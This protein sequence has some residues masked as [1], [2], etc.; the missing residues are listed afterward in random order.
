ML[1]PDIIHLCLQ[2]ALAEIEFSVT[3][4]RIDTA[5]PSQAH[6]TWAQRCA[7]LRQWSLVSRDWHVV[8]SELLYARLVLE[9]N[10]GGPRPHQIL[11]STYRLPHG[12][13]F[14]SKTQLLSINGRPTLTDE[15][16]R[17]LTDLFQRS[18]NLMSL[19][20]Y[21][22]VLIHLFINCSNAAL[23]T[24]SLGGTIRW[25]ELVAFISRHSQLSAVSIARLWLENDDHSTTTGHFLSITR[26]DVSTTH[27]SAYGFLTH[28]P[29]LASLRLRDLQADEVPRLAALGGFDTI[30]P[31]AAHVGAHQLGCQPDQ[32][33]LSSV[34]AIAATALEALAN[35]C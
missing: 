34:I 15:T 26:L 23:R 33:S 3:G 16:H 2:T 27:L 14:L 10:S 31:A 6:I 25:S 21:D 32:H 8:S 5:L 13:D 20:L 18:P 1:P 22:A 19:H 9:F 24:L 28:F 4:L 17:A 29:A 30:A 12:A 35:R 7:L 11:H